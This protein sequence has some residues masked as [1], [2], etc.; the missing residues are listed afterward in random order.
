MDKVSPPLTAKKGIQDSLEGL[1][2]LVPKKRQCANITNKETV[3]A[4]VQPRRGQ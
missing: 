3:K 2:D 1:E 4:G